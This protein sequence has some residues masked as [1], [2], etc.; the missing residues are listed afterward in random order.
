[1]RFPRRIA[2][3]HGRS[4]DWWTHEIMLRL[5]ALG[6]RFEYQVCVTGSIGR[7]DYR[8]FLYDLCWL[9]Y[10]NKQMKRAALVLECEW[11]SSD[12][13]WIDFEKLLLS[14]A[15]L[16]VMIF[17]CS[18][19]GVI[20]QLFKDMAEAVSQYEGLPRQKFLLCGWDGGTAKRFLYKVLN[21]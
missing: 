18:T 4:S 12:A 21:G 13:I 20:Q 6:K 14:N 9:L 5:C 3:D 16:R 8:G 7:A 10:A 2:Q 19:E 1:M 17:Q 15:D 11:G